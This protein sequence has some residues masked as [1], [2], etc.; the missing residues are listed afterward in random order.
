[1]AAAFR[2]SAG[3]AWSRSSTFWDS[4]SAP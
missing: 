4:A 2:A 3:I 1:L